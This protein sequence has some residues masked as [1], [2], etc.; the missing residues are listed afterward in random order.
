[1]IRTWLPPHVVFSQMALAGVSDDVLTES[2]RNMVLAIAV[3][4]SVP[5]EA[6]CASLVVGAP[7]GERWERMATELR[8]VLDLLERRGDDQ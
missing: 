6:V 7:T 4:H 1:M 2:A 3:R 8:R 5:L